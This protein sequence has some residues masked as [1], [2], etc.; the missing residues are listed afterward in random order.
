[1]VSS[2]K[3]AVVPNSSGGGELYF[4]A[5]VVVKS[6]RDNKMHLLVVSYLNS[7]YFFVKLLQSILA[8]KNLE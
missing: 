7:S 2:I 4:G 1:M 6:N 8:K 3:F 5:W